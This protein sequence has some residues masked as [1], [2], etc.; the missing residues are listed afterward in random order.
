MAEDMKNGMDYEATSFDDGDVLDFNQARRKD[1]RTVAD[2]RQE[3]EDRAYIDSLPSSERYVPSDIEIGLV[4]GHNLKL[5]READSDNAM[6]EG[7]KGFE[8]A[9]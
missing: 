6:I 9:A 4:I 2:V 5:V 3:R 7:Y 1:L 8:L